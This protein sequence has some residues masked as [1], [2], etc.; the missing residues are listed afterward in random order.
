VGEID[1][2]QKDAEYRDGK[3]RKALNYVPPLRMLRLPIPPVHR[4]LPSS[5]SLNVD[6]QNVNRLVEVGFRASAHVRGE[7]YVGELE[8]GVASGQ[9]FRVGNAVAGVQRRGKERKERGKKT[10]CRGNGER[11]SAH[12]VDRGGSG[13]DKKAHSRLAAPILKVPVASSAS[14]SDGFACKASTSF[15]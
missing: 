8:E 1:E 12:D 11:R 13:K 9:R 3:V 6:L 10:S 2:K 14:P 4:S 15:S 7:D 5:H